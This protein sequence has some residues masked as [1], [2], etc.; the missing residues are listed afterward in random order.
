MIHRKLF[1]FDKILFFHKHFTFYLIEAPI[2][3]IFRGHCQFVLGFHESISQKLPF[4]P[5]TLDPLLFVGP[6]LF[7]CSLC[8]VI[9][10]MS[11]AP[12]APA[13][14]FATAPVV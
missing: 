14:D 8:R 13:A 4:S 12:L 3:R 9:P 11:F 5:L 2:N 10:G 7:C 1:H 6:L